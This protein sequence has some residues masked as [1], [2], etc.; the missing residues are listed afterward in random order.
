MNGVRKWLG[1][2]M[3][4]LALAAVSLPTVAA[5]AK[6]F[7]LTMAPSTVTSSP[8]SLTAKFTNL[9]PNGNSV[10]NTV[11]LT[12]PTGVTATATFPNGGKR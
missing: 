11:I 4:A 6:I 3:S 2:L 12:P 5:P 9:T 7:G 10:I 1:I 8:A